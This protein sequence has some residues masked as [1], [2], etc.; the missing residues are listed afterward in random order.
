MPRSDDIRFLRHRLDQCRE[1]KEML[2]SSTSNLR[3]ALLVAMKKMSPLDLAKFASEHHCA[4]TLIY[5]AVKK[6]ERK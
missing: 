4:A 5:I 1:E 3:T 6:Y 2:S